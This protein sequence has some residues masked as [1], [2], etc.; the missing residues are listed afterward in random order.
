MVLEEML[1]PVEEKEIGMSMYRFE[2]GDAEI[3]EVV[4]NE[5]KAVMQSSSVSHWKHFACSL[6]HRMML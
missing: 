1:N 3:V 4:Q 5:M 6:G 2:G